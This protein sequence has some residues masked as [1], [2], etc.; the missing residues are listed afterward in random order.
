MVEVTMV[1][2]SGVDVVREMFEAW[3]AHDL[4]AVYDHLSE[5]YT[6]YINGGIAKRSRAEAQELDQVLYDT[7]PDYTRTVEELWGVGD[8]V[9]AR[10]IISG[11][12]R[13]GRRFEL[14]IAGI[15]GV[16]GGRVIEAHLF[17][18]PAAAVDPR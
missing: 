16:T 8:R 1:P 15:F 6:E 12:M 14:A 3:N 9:A 4:A 5:D 11:T 13:D 10:F 17:F 7:V 18:D 2:G